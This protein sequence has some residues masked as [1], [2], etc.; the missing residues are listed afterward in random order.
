MKF[1]YVS[2]KKPSE[3]READI[4][5][6]EVE[7]LKIEYEKDKK[8]FWNHWHC[9]NYTEYIEVLLSMNC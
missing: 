6:N 9:H 2:L 8:F 1:Q 7:R 4:P 5:E 3:L